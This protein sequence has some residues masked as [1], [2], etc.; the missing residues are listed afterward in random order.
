MWGRGWVRFY[1]REFLTEKLLEREADRHDAR[2][3]LP[4]AAAVKF[5]KSRVYVGSA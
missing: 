5:R 4:N 1:K 3:G 2:P